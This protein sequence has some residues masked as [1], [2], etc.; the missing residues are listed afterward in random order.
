MAKTAAVA[1]K[2]V[3]VAELPPKGPVEGSAAKNL[4][5]LSSGAQSV[6]IDL[7]KVFVS[8]AENVRDMNADAYSEE[9]IGEMMAQIE[10]VGGLMQPIGITKVVPSEATENKQ[11]MLVWGFRR[12]L[13]LLAL[14][15]DDPKYAKNVP[16]KLVT[17]GGES[18]GATRFI[19]I[20]ENTRENLNPMEAALAINEALTDKEC[21]FNQTDIAR[22]LGTPVSTISNLMRLLRLPPQ[23]QELISSGKL[24]HG[25]AKLL[26]GRVPETLWGKEAIKASGMTYGDWQNYLDKE[27][28]TDEEDEGTEEGGKKSSSQKPAKML[29]S[30]EVS[31][32]LGFFAE[33]AKK[34]DA[35]NKT[36]TEKDLIAAREDTLKTVLLNP[37]TAL[38]KEIQ[39][40][41]EQ[42]AKQ[43]QAEEQQAEAK[44]AEEKFYKEQVKRLE[45]ILD[46]PVDPSKPN[47]PRPMLSEVYTQVG[48]EIFKLNDEQRKALGFQLPTGDKAADQ[49]VQKLADTYQGVIRERAENKAKRE[50]AKAEA[51]AKA[52]AEKAKAEAAGTAAAP[53]ADSAPAP[54][55]DG[56]AVATPAVPVS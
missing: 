54:V 13:A 1:E 16:A 53:A 25:H 8:K 3:E 6:A 49:I 38:S 2:S 21:D 51:A 11:Y 17:K 46:A 37:D 40:Y 15:A 50:K 18:Q 32:Y 19:Q 29:R 30:T 43:E 27:Y 56:K 4:Q 5:S 7:D 52:E 48:L 33:K 41:L 44:K 36:Y 47:A 23:V 24:S 45:E 42:L 35:T 22:M 28:S 12:T 14:A 20:L 34:A 31:K 39:P 10:A 55:G 26:L 9:S